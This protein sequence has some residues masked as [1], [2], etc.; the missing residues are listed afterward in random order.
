MKLTVTLD[1]RFT[2]TSDGRVWS[3]TAYT[4][5]FWDRYLAVFDGVRV[6]ARAQLV[7]AV[8][9]SYKSVTDPWVEFIAVPYYLGPWQYFRARSQIRRVLR[10][11]L[12]DSEAVLCRV[13]SLLANDLLPLLWKEG[14][15]YGLAVGGDPHAAF[16][17]G[18][19]QHPL[20]PLFRVIAT[21]ALK[22]QCARA[23][24]VRY[25]TERTLQKEYPAVGYQVGISDVEIG[26]SFLRSEPRVFSAKGH[27]EA[28]L[29]F[30]GSLAQMYKAPDVLIKAMRI[31]AAENSAVRLKIVGDGRHRPAL[32]RLAR[33]L[34]LASRI[35]FAGEL[36][37][38]AMHNELD[39][40]TLFVLPSRTEGLPRAMI[41]A[42][43]RAVPCIGTTVGGIPELLPPDDMVPPGDPQQLAAKIMQV[44][45][46][47]AR[48]TRMS[49]RNLR[50]AGDFRSEALN[51]RR[52]EFYSFLRTTT[53]RWLNHRK[54]P[55]PTLALPCGSC[56]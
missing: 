30:V 18:A 25:V 41:E 14:R 49:A 34:Q 15:P 17:R 44:L 7:D 11:A 31:L 4:R 12:R 28:S 40:A 26:D 33:K 13:P 20:R 52:T 42:M 22:R 54:Q 6:I 47:S 39:K 5:T 36:P 32:E 23:A 16:A 46:D 48:L 19:V 53:E 29:L 9:S 38:T 24:A 45:D 2:R 21:R 55:C 1:H 51:R 56:T 37:R 3:R 50:R 27:T 10:A 43:A 8:D 35:E